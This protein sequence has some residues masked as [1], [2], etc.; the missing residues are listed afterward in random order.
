MTPERDPAEP[1]IARV[2]TDILARLD[3][4]AADMLRGVLSL[5]SACDAVRYAQA[6]DGARY[7][8]AFPDTIDRIQRALLQQA[9]PGQEEAHALLTLWGFLTRHLTTLFTHFEGYSGSADKAGTVLRS[10]L[11][12]VL[13]GAPIAYP[14]EPA[15]ARPMT[16]LTTPEESWDFFLAL[17]SMY[18]GDPIP[19]L[20]HWASWS[21]RAPL[22][23]QEAP[24]G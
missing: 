12:H 15:Y 22:I 17:R 18:R 1:E 19:Y 11:R 21:D 16:L 24:H 3:A 13:A 4:D 8:R 9:L 14:P 23:P 6:G 5:K 20:R 10:W 7:A 2:L